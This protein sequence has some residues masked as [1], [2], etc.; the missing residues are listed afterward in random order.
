[1][2]GASAF[3]VGLQIADTCFSLSLGILKL[4]RRLHNA[5][6]DIRQKVRRLKQMAALTESMEADFKLPASSPIRDALTPE[7]LQQLQDMLKL[8]Q[9]EINHLGLILGSAGPKPT[10]N[11]LERQQRSIRAVAKEEAIRRHLNELQ[12]LSS[13]MSLWY[14]HQLLRTCSK[15]L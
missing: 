11:F 10:D 6:A 15:Y 1:M 13:R 4:G 5:P 12:E 8:C 7:A 14:N 3:A 9:E 2:D